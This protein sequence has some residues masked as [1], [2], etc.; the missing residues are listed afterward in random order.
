MK[1]NQTSSVYNSLNN[2]S[3][4]EKVAFF[5][6]MYDNYMVHKE[7]ERLAKEKRKLER[8]SKKKSK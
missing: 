2:L 6:K 4:Q 8:L 5:S 7:E 1:N 3:L